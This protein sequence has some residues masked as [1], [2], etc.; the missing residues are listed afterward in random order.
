M[1]YLGGTTIKSGD[2]AGQDPAGSFTLSPGEQIVV[3]DGR[4]GTAVDALSFITNQCNYITLL[5]YIV[6]SHYYIITVIT[7]YKPSS[8][9]HTKIVSI[10][11]KVTKLRGGRKT[12]KSISKFLLYLPVV[13]TQVDP[14]AKDLSKADLLSTGA[15]PH[16]LLCPPHQ[17][18]PVAQI[19]DGRQYQLHPGMLCEHTVKYIW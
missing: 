18:H 9:S 8:K 7:C 4:S 10:L 2:D 16:L 3:I 11:S 6:T 15:W 19:R 5:H 14:V 13:I 12:G 1:T 17:T